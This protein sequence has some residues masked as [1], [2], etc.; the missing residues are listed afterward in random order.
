PPY[1]SHLIGLKLQ[2]KAHLPWVADFRDSWIGW[3]STPQWRPKFARRIEKSMEGAVLKHASKILT[4]SHGVKED[5]LSRHPELQDDRWHLLPNGFDAADFQ[6]IQPIPDNERVIV[7]YVGSLYGP[8]NP[9]YLL[10]ALEKIENESP[11]S[12]DNLC[13]RLIGR[14]GASIRNRIQSSSVS[15]LF[16]FISYVSHQKSLSYLLGSDVSLLIIDDAPTNRGILTG[17][18]FEYIGAGNPILALTP[19]GEAAD[20]IRSKN[21]GWVVPPKD[22]QAIQHTVQQILAIKS[23]DNCHFHPCKNLQQ[24]FDRRHQTG[25]LAKILDELIQ[26]K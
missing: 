24:Q 10:R 20:L 16:E 3:L 7:T 18:L 4:V 12:L 15:H 2:R 9:E 17:K 26:R 25:A 8:R 11:G 21:L 6:N 13:F 14:I 19:E 23:L 1:T 5:L 22:V